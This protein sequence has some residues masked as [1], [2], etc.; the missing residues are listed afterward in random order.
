MRQE[1]REYLPKEGDTYPG[2]GVGPNHMTTAWGSMKADWSK[3]CP[4]ELSKAER[5]DQCFG[6]QEAVWGTAGL[7]ELTEIKKDVDPKSLF[8]CFGCVGYVA[9]SSPSPAPTPGFL[10]S[11]SPTPLSEGSGS[12]VF[13][14]SAY[15]GMDDGLAR[16]GF[17]FA[18]LQLFF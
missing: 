6:L 2:D 18:A 8:Q 7:E 4:A 14:S 5:E 11:P 1:I 16:M 12:N 3:P 13:M 9:P 10:I 15:P 17:V